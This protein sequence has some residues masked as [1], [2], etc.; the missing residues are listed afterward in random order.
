MARKCRRVAGQRNSRVSGRVMIHSNTVL[1]VKSSQ[2][3]IMRPLTLL[4][5]LKLRILKHPRSRSTASTHRTLL[6]MTLLLFPYRMSSIRR[7]M[8]HMLPAA[9]MTLP[10]LRQQCSQSTTHTSLHSTQFQHLQPLRLSIQSRH[11][12]HLSSTLSLSH[13]SLHR[14]KRRTFMPLSRPSLLKCLS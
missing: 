8:G 5:V 4:Q 9:P 3:V 11:H 2:V 13:Q 1:Q 10:L 7:P 12:Q 6:R 14:S